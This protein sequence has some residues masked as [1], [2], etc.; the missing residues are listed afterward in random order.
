MLDAILAVS[1]FEA[2]S[3]AFEG[4]SCCVSVMEANFGGAEVV[5]L[6][7]MIVG[8]L[9]GVIKGSGRLMAGS[10]EGFWGSSMVD[11]AELLSEGP[12]GSS[13]GRSFVTPLTLLP[14][15]LQPSSSSVGVS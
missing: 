4:G 10:G 1:M 15:L 14:L 9:V 5:L 13:L 7:V 8:G 6:S 3:S 11:T 2:D 12:S